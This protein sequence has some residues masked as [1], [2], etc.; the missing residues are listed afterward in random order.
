ML[1]IFNIK[2]KIITMILSLIMIYTIS[3]SSLCKKFTENEC[4]SPCEW[5]SKS[6]SCLKSSDNR[7]SFLQRK[8]KDGRKVCNSFLSQEKCENYSDVGCYWNSR[9]YNCYYDSNMNKK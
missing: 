5:N 1:K 2:M 6:N 4:K 3:T 8:K 9:N 7:I